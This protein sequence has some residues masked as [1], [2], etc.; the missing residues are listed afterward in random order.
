MSERT[1]KLKDLIREG[2]RTTIH[3]TLSSVIHEVTEEELR[4]A[5]REPAFKDPLMEIIRLELRQ[6]IEDLRQNGR[7]RRPSRR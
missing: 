3:D 1:P 5:L 2:V 7:T 4:A 6:A